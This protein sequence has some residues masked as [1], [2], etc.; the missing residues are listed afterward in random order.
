MRYDRAFWSEAFN[1]ILL[2][3]HHGLW[4]EEREITVL[5]TELFN[6]PIKVF[7]DIFPECISVGFKNDASLHVCML[8]KVCLSD[9]IKIPLRKIR[10]LIGNALHSPMLADE[11]VQ[12]EGPSFCP[13]CISSPSV[14]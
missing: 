7:L 11:A 6:A 9:N 12:T 1:V 8:S 10:C 13:N 14:W 5:Y 3:I 2:L 4:N